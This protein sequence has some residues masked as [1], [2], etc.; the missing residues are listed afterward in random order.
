[1]RAPRR[2]ATCR[3]CGREFPAGELD[4]L[5]WCPQCRGLVLP[6]AARWARG[7]AIAVTLALVLWISL[8]IGPTT[9]FLVAWGAMVVATYFVVH[10]IVRRVAFEVIR[11]RGVSSPE[12]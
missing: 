11:A 2:A 12:G 6:R 10:R 7:I 8:T 1:L 5:R 3:N 4:E 9:R